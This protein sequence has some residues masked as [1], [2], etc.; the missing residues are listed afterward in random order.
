VEDNKVFRAL[1]DPTRRLL[2]DQLFLRDGRSLTELESRLDMTRFGVMKHLRVLEEA[3]LVATRKVGREKLHYLNPI[4]IQLIYDRWIGKYAA[5]RVSAL[6]DLKAALEGATTVTNQVLT[7][8]KQVYEVFIKATPER[9]WEA[10]TKPEF[11]SRY[12][13]GSRVMSDLRVGS[14]FNYLPAE[15]TATLVEGRVLESARPRR[16]VHT[17]RALWDAEVS[18]DAP[19]RVTWE[20]TGM[21]GGMT[22]LTVIHDDFDG[23][24]ATFKQVSGGWPWILSNLKSFLETGETL[25]PPA[26]A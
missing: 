12:F 20:L 11:T 8:P 5:P 25:P 1:A 16:L 9:V 14:P 10:L 26:A 21:A 2:L 4:P 15:G 17:W 3:G 23:E 18:K 6:A 7:K 19:S 24:T 22:R 13:H